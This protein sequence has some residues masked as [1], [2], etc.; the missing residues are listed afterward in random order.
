MPEHGTSKLPQDTYRSNSDRGF[1]VISLVL[2]RNFHLSLN[3]NAFNHHGG[4]SEAVVV[5]VGIALIDAARYKHSG[6]IIS[7]RR[8]GRERVA[9][10]ALLML[11]PPAH[12][13]S[14]GLSFRDPLAKEC[15][16]IE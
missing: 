11:D 8:T 9:G 13:V 14:E 6:R 4:G 1:S 10:D 2:L 15:E 3:I 12:R 7:T 16:W 5:H